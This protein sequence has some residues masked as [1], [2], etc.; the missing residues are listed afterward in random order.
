VRSDKLFSMHIRHHWVP[1]A[2]RV[3][4]EELRKLAVQQAELGVSPA[5][6]TLRH[7]RP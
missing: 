2:L 3:V 6:L 5:H 7:V 1:H 4:K